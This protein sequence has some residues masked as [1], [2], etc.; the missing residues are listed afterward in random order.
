MRSGSSSANRYD[1]QPKVY[2]RKCMRQAKG[3]ISTE[4]I[5]GSILLK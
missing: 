1:N 5:V 2:I 3:R 4:N